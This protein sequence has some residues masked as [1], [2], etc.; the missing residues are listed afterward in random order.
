MSTSFQD[1]DY[2]FQKDLKPC[3]ML[4]YSHIRQTVNILILGLG[5]MVA[6]LL[7]TE[8]YISLGNKRDR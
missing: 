8:T 2:P 3:H 5:N 6:I 7:S 1:D 4:K